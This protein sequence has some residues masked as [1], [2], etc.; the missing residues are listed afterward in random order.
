[1]SFLISDL[2]CDSK[3]QKTHADHCE[4][5]DPKKACSEASYESHTGVFPLIASIKHYK[6]KETL[7]GYLEDVL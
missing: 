6:E 3:R 1:M 7:A 4:R 2:A 5:L